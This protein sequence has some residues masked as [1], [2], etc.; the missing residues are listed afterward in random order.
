MRYLKFSFLAFVVLFFTAFSVVNRETVSVSLF[1]LPFAA[2]LPLFLLAL[3]CFSLG[4]LVAGFWVNIKFAK[5]KRM[6]SREHKRV[7]ALQNELA[8]IKS[9]Q[10]ANA[11]SLPL[12]KSA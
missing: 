3:I 11:P 12:N 10:P 7:M 1:P 6:L 5:T 4:A 2:D 9:E 8:G